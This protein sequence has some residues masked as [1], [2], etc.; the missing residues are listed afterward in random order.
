MHELQ[1]LKTIPLLNSWQLSEPGEKQTNKQTNKQTMRQTLTSLVTAIP[2]FLL[3]H[4]MVRSG[5]CPG[6]HMP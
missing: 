1:T 3:E 5:K 2:L 4:E 6:I